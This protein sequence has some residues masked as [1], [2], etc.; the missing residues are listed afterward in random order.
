MTI[1]GTAVD[2][3][4]ALKRTALLPESPGSKSQPWLRSEL[5]VAATGAA[6]LS[7]AWDADSAG[8]QLPLGSRLPAL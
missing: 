7:V 2:P 1:T 4:V 8:I 5:A 3:N 6:S